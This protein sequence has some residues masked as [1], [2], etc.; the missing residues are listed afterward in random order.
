MPRI[1]TIEE[2]FEYQMRQCLERFIDDFELEPDS[3]DE[4]FKAIW[5][6]RQEFGELVHNRMVEWM[7]ED[8]WL[9]L[10]QD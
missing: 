3:G 10:V 2:D 1:R 4:L 6:N 7:A 5:N 9:A 8:D